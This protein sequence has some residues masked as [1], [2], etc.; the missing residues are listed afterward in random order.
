MKHCEQT[1]NG[2]AQIGKPTGRKLSLH[3][4]S[5]NGSNTNTKTL[6]GEITSGGKSDGYR[7]F[8][9]HI[10]FFH[11]FH[12]QTL[13]N[14]VHATEGEDRTPRRTHIFLVSRT[15]DRFPKCKEETI[16]SKIQNTVMRTVLTNWFCTG[17]SFRNNIFD[18]RIDGAGSHMSL[19]T[20]GEITQMAT[21]RRTSCSRPCWRMNDV[22]KLKTQHFVARTCDRRSH[23]RVAQDL[24]RQMF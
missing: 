7:L 2:T 13:A 18:F 10:G 9:S 20:C 17:D 12:V 4:L 15:C 3:H 19:G 11:R 22:L 21:M 16:W 23:L 24:T 6:N 1:W 5:N 14:V 8:P